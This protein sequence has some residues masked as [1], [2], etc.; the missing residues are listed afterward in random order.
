MKLL[1][2]LVQIPSYSGQEDKLAN[3]I[4][5]FL[6]KNHVSARIQNGNVI[7]HIAGLDQTKTLIFNAHMDTIKGKVACKIKSD[8]VYGLGASDDK[9]AIA[10]MLYLAK[11]LKAPGIDIWF[12]FVTKEETDGTGTENFLNWF[13]A[14]KYFKSYKDISAIIGEPTG[15]EV[16][17]I[18]HRGNIF[19]KLKAAGISGHSAKEYQD[20]ELAIEKILKALG[21]IKA[22]KIQAGINITSLTTSEKTLNQIPRECEAII[23]IRTTPKLDGKI[24][25]FIRKT[26]GHG[27]EVSEVEKGR[28]SGITSSGSHIVKIFKKIMPGVLLRISVGSTDLSQF[29]QK[30]IPAVVFGP[31]EKEVIHNPDEYIEVKKVL[32][33][34]KIYKKIIEN[35]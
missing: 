28:I 10:S 4:L 16:L 27:V 2:Q 30:G 19:L 20:S 3:F 9:G 29:T 7:A 33:C 35:Y 1:Q 32:E 12:T 25:E 24:A 5:D 8:R 13:T 31:G 34:V 14:S 17:E 6:H 15:L 26:V 22:A 11:D 21:K 18:G 23:D